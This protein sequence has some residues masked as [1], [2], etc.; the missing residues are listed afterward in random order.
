[1]VGTRAATPQTDREPE[2]RRQRGRPATLPYVHAT[3]PACPECGSFDLNKY[4]AMKEESD[5]SRLTY[6]LCRN[7]GQRMKVVWEPDNELF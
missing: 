1:M 6:E 2:P 7:C 5:G 4:G 3:R